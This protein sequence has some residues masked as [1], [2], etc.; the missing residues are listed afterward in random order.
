MDYENGSGDEDDRT[1]KGLGAVPS[2]KRESGQKTISFL[3]ALC[4][5]SAFALA[6][7]FILDIVEPRGMT[8]TIFGLFVLVGGL[9]RLRSM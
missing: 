5:L 7:M 6:W 9:E 2:K 3:G 1:L 8:W 4:L